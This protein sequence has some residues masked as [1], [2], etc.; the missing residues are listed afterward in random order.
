[1]I[2]L[3]ISLN[4]PGIA[5]WYSLTRAFCLAWLSVTV[6]SPL[7]LLHSK[8]E[9]SLVRSSGKIVSFGFGRRQTSSMLFSTH[10]IPSSMCQRAVSQ[11]IKLPL[12]R[13]LEKDVFRG[14]SNILLPQNVCLTCKLSNLWAL[15]L[16]GPC[17]SSWSLSPYLL[18]PCS[19]LESCSHTAWYKLYTTAPWE[20]SYFPDCHLGSSHQSL[21]LE[22]PHS[23]VE[24]MELHLI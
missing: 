18:V 6:I 11:L 8:C 17:P 20:L 14:F 1:M 9:S 2:Y 5:L 19:P 16:I 7:S 21:Y 15:Y 10:S 3:L 24:E 4:V 22:T 12:A 13:D 23:V